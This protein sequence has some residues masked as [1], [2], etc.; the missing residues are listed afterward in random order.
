MAAKKHK[1]HKKPN[2]FAISVP[3]CGYSC[4]KFALGGTFKE[5][6]PQTT[7]HFTLFFTSGIQPVEITLRQEPLPLRNGCLGNDLEQGASREFNKTGKVR[8]GGS[9]T[10]FGQM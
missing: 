2:C 6:L 3:F 8:P 7:Q 9:G 10:A 4:I 5:R 1:G